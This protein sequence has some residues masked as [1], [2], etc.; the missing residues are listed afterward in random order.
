MGAFHYAK[1]G[2]LVPELFESLTPVQRREGAI[3]A[4]KMAVCLDA[5]AWRAW[6]RKAPALGPLVKRARALK[7]KIC[8]TDPYEQRGVREVLNFGHTFGHVLESLSRFRLSHGDAVGLGMLC[9]LDVGVALGVTS[10]A[11][12][13][14]VEEVLHAQAGVLPRTELAKT[15]RKATLEE[16]LRD[17]RRGQ[18]GRPRWRGADGA[19]RVPRPLEVADRSGQALAATRRAV[20]GRRGVSGP[21]EKAVVDATRLH[22]GVLSPPPSKSDAQRAQVIA[23][24]LGRPEWAPFAADDLSLPEDMRVMATGLAKL[25]EGGSVEID[26]RDG[27]AP[28]RFLLSQAAV[29]PGAKVR[30]VGSARLGERPHAAL[31]SA[32]RGAGVEIREGSPWPIEVDGRSEFSS[33]RFEIDGSGSSQ[34]VSSLLLAAA[35]LSRRDRQRWEV[36]LTSPTASLGYLGL[37]LDWLRRSGFAVERTESV[38]ALRFAEEPSALPPVPGD[39]SS[40]GYLLVAAWKT[41][42]HVTGVD[43]SAEH[44]DR[45]ILDVLTQVGLRLVEHEDGVSVEGTAQRGLVASG[46]TCPDLLPTLAALACALPGPSEL[47]EVEILRGKESDRLAGIE[48][49]VA[50]A[51]GRTRREGASLVIEPPRALGQVAPLHSR[52]DHRMAMS[53]ATL[54]IL[55]G[56]ELELEGP[57]CVGKSFPRFWEQL[58]HV[59][60]TLHRHRKEAVMST[61]TPDSWRK[62]PA[63]QQPS[64]TEAALE[65]VLGRLRT[66][67][68][69]VSIGEVESLKSQLAEAAAGKRFILQGG[70]CAERFRDCNPLTITRKLK[71]L[72]QMSLVLTYG[73]RRPVVRIGRIAGQFAKPRS[74]DTEKVNGVE[75]PAYRGDAVNALEA[76]PELR[77]P[78]PRRLE[79]AY[80]TSATTLNFIR[81]LV[82]GGFAN[83]RAPEHWQLDFIPEGA[84]DGGFREIAS[85]IHDAIDYLASLGGVNESLRSVDFFTSHEALLL[86]YE[87]ALTRSPREGGRAYDLSAHFLWLGERTRQL[88]SAHV[89]YLRGI[90]NPIGVKVGPDAKLDDVL[91]LADKLD[92]NREPGRLTLITRMGSDRIAAS[93]PALVRGVR[94]EGRQVVWS[95]D[96]MHG[97][98]VTLGGKKTREFHRIAE[99]LTSAFEIHRAEGQPAP[100]RPLRAHRREHHRVRR[101]RRGPLERGPPP[102]LR[103]R[104]RPAAELLAEPGDRVPPQPAAQTGAPRRARPRERVVEAR[105]R[106]DSDAEPPVGG[107]KAMKLR[108]LIELLTGALLLTR[109][110]I[111]ARRRLARE[112]TRA[113]RAA[114][115]GRLSPDAPLLLGPSAVPHR[116]WI[117]NRRLRRR[118]DSA[119]H[120]PGS[121][122][123]RRR[124]QLESGLRPRADGRSSWVLRNA[125]RCGRG[126]WRAPA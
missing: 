6:Q 67:P 68:P 76:D 15:L 30:F 103:H 81:A 57:D 98:S 41:G 101:R 108:N 79:Q 69:L 114:G 116:R 38:I 66:L 92:P 60:V 53:A 50:A 19:A 13:E 96:P 44:P 121:R 61:W 104:L 100:R 77:R 37:T 26:C 14:S 24:A 94:R 45:A 20:E 11:V 55:A 119:V 39:W 83:L 110:R 22:S 42:A 7:A 16:I 75:L 97:N 91:A 25:R 85:R 112:A 95:C 1:E 9:A 78:D 33:R 64:W 28:L 107:V 8:K 34:Y 48:T 21:S 105:V 63:R 35:A 58:S 51:G 49:L 65:P 117:G 111:R 3:E 115:R 31:I 122:P 18:E 27:G 47:R 109:S 70:D 46:E 120:A 106:A 43:R 59:G 17:P 4:W 126:S 88:D 54:A 40:L 72:L 84:N 123:V 62:H 125:A 73:A 10:P 74:S 89:E 86:P 87:E 29:T 71:I 124:L 56:T 2:L 80:F 52:G 99:E 32:L 118:W 23:H 12:A 102:Q 36:R 93:L 5:P 90:G 82:E 113:H